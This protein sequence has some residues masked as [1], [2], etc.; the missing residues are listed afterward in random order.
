MMIQT[1]A[2]RREQSAVLLR[3]DRVEMNARELAEIEQRLAEGYYE[4]DAEALQALERLVAEVR[5]FREA[6]DAP[7]PASIEDS[8]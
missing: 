8:Y 7:L 3:S 4:G 5:R 2:A 1:A 6:T